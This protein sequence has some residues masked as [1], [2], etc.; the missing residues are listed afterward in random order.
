MRP[1][2]YTLPQLWHPTHG[3]T[4]IWLALAEFLQ[5]CQEL[6]ILV[7]LQRP[8]VKVL[9]SL[10]PRD[11][12]SASPWRRLVRFSHSWQIWKEGCAESVNC[13]GQLQ[14][15]CKVVQA[16]RSFLLQIVRQ[17]PKSQTTTTIR[18]AVMEHR[19]RRLELG[20]SAGKFM[21][22]SLCGNS[23]LGRFGRLGF[24]ITKAWFKLQWLDSWV[25]VNM[26]IVMAYAVWEPYWHG[27]VWSVGATTQ[28]WLRLFYQGTP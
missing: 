20:F 11:W 18:S 12:C 5:P 6:G 3:H 25:S 10:I 15:A 7:A 4:R 2:H 24:T 13:I 23:N 17:W 19:S 21:S 22:G 27:R 16:G 26:P 8:R 9:S 1:P 28:K 14:Q